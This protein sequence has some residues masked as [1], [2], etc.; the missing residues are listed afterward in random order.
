MRDF[1][2]KDRCQA[3]TGAQDNAWSGVGKTE[4]TS[5]G[6]R[7]EASSRLCAVQPS[8][9]DEG[10][11]C[12]EN[13]VTMPQSEWVQRT[14]LEAI[15]LSSQQQITGLKGEKWFFSETLNGC[16]L[17]ARRL[18]K[19][20][21]DAKQKSDDDDWCTKT[22]EFPRHGS[23]KTWSDR[24]QAAKDECRDHIKNAAENKTSE[25]IV[26]PPDYPAIDGATNCRTLYQVTI[27]SNKSIDEACGKEFMHF[28]ATEAN[29]TRVVFLVPSSTSPHF[30]ISF[31][32][33][34]KKVS[35][36]LAEFWVVGINA[37]Q[38]AQGKR[39]NA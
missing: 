14:V 12:S 28:G 34:C 1:I 38:E 15:A 36:E 16:K 5:L 37:A 23:V 35:L 6:G 13:W 39:V 4:V 27:R 9:T 10:I 22:W 30:R 2:H 29:K 21:A 7:L 20:L 17:Q 25:L 26:C 11:L 18:P 24:T 31:K 32:T 3:F 33:G 8:L 19:Q